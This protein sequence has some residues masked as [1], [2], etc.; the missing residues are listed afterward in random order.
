LLELSCKTALTAAGA[1]DYQYLFHI[2]KIVRK[3][4]AS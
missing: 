3:D 2:P 4:S 1:T